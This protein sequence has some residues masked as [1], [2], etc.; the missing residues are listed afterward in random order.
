MWLFIVGVLIVCALIWD[1]LFKR[2][3]YEI[4]KNS[5]IPGPFYTWPL[6]GD[7]LET[8]GSDTLNVFAI[9]ERLGV[10]FGKVFRLWI[11]QRLVL[12]VR[13]PKYF[14]VILS[15]QHL[16]KKPFIYDMFS[17]WLGDGLLLSYGPKWHARRKILTPTYH[18]KIL[19]EFIEVFDRQSRVL[20]RKLAAKADGKTTFNVFPIVCLTALDNIAET[21]MGV[22]INAQE[23]PEFPYAMAVKDATDVL[24]TRAVRP[25]LYFD[26]SFLLIAFPSY[27]K[28]RKSVKIMHDFTNKVINDRRAAMGS[29]KQHTASTP[30]DLAEGQKKRMAFLD[31]L[32]QATV[33]GKPLAQEDI[34][35]EV[36][37]FMF[38]GH[39]TTTSGISFC[40]YLLS[41]HASVQQ[42]VFEEII[43][44]LGADK[45]KPL[46]MRDLQNLKYLEA[47]IK[48][49]L[50]M[51]PSVPIIARECL[52]DIQIG[53]QTIPANT[54]IALLFY[55]AGRDPD[56]FY[57]AND[58]N[59]ERFY[60]ASSHDNINPFAYVPFSAGPRNCIGQKFA[61]LEM[62]STISRVLRYFELLPLG[63]EVIPVL[64]LILRSANGVQLGLRARKF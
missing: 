28:L 52:Q 38:E 63:A 14:E 48:E 9:F 51:F 1:Y 49:T 23:N 42:R 21:A 27:L 8:V 12:V 6:I 36:D 22:Q 18:F 11:F 40:L 45:D 17:C 64:N 57:Q 26:I 4:L 29:Q 44:V 37:T 59:P 61:M 33:D 31:V 41:R 58:F 62:K 10:R 46:T 60:S 32:L 13:D 30:N 20:V 55:A 53:N 15:S 54:N 19:E 56:Y 16:I 47:V 25:P 3:R 2:R 7:V 5:R 34:R 35:E 43:E 24:A 39:D 50:R